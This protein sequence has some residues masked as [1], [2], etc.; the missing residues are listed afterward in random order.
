MRKPRNFLRSGIRLFSKDDSSR[1]GEAPDFASPAGQFSGD[2]AVAAT[3]KA[4]DGSDLDGTHV[5]LNASGSNDA[6]V[7]GAFD[8]SVTSGG[9]F[10]VTN[11]A[12]SGQWKRAAPVTGLLQRHSIRTKLFF[13]VVTLVFTIVLLT[14]VGLVGFYRYRSLADAISTRATELSLATELSQWATAA[15]DSNT[16]ICLMKSREGMIDSSVLAES[17]LKLERANFDQAMFELLLTFNRYADAIGLDYSMRD[18]ALPASMQADN[19]GGLSATLIDTQEQRA[20]VVAIGNTIHQ[21]DRMRQ[22]PRAVAVYA[23]NG[24]NELSGRLAQLVY[25][26]Q[27]HLDLIHSQMASFSDHVKLQHQA[28]IAGAWIALAIAALITATMVWYFQMMV[29]GPFSNLVMGARLVARGQYRHRIEMGSEDEIG[30]LGEILNQ[31][32]DRFRHSMLHIQ[33]ICK[34]KDEEVKVRSREV[35]RN[36]QLAG[37]GF[38]AAGF[39]HEI[40]NPMAAIAWSAEAL[41]SRV[42]DLLMYP[43]DERFLDSEFM[44]T[45]QENLQRI[46]GEA[47]RCKSIT[48][49]MLSFSRVGHVDRDSISVGPLVSDVVEMIGTLGKYK[50]KKISV[51]VNEDVIAYANSQEIRQVVLN[52]VTNAMESVDSDGRV[53]IVLRN[54]GAFAS[55]RVRDSGCGMTPDVMQHLFEPF[56]TRRRDGTGTGLGLSISYRI[57]SQH[58]GQLI[59][60]SDGEGCGSEFELRLPIRASVSGTA[61]SSA[62]NVETGRKWQ[63]ATPQAA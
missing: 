29:I 4:D 58:G 37:V 52:L 21:S 54:D 63:D 40:N 30:E 8:S 27:E 20:S 45:M 2:Q 17:D 11:V 56:Y 44:E 57:V 50:C 59:P 39:A 35:I 6:S 9:S 14:I 62:S 51:D 60:R 23:Q 38:L 26:T 19:V 41:E 49:R 7:W 47:Y 24:C 28:G 25:Q 5:D 46:Q 10:A 36:E 32:T 31:M 53:D 1:R 42:N 43:E 13:G 22:D 48:E 18:C 16:R 55:I 12:D 15:R 3:N 61:K 34:E 33:K